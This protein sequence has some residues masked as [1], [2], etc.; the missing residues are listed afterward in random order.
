VPH[1]VDALELGRQAYADEAWVDAYE[2]FS[3]ADQELQLA[4]DDLELLARAA[5][6][7]GRDDD[8]VAALE[9][10]HHAHVSADDLEP[11]IRCA[12]WIGH[13]W[14]FRGDSSRAVGWF[15]RGQRLLERV[16]HDCVERGWLL[17]PVWLEQMGRGDYEVGYETALEAAR[18][19]ERF[20]DLDLTWLARDEQARALVK[21]GRAEEGLRLVGEVFVAT[22]A[23]ELSPIVTG[24]VYCNTVIFCHDGFAHRHART[25]TVGLTQ[26]CDRQPQ[27]VAHN[28]LCRVHRAEILELEGEWADALDEARQ[29]AEC[30]TQGA[31]NQIACGAAHYRQ[32]EIHRLRGDREDAAQSYHEASRHGFE[33]Q[34]GLALLRLAEGDSSAAAAAI[35]R[36]VGERTQPLERA[37]LLPAFVQ[38]MLAVGEHDRA[39]AG[40]DELE[41]IARTQV[42]EL[43]DAMSAH[44]RGELTLSEGDAAGALA[45]LRRAA[46]TWQAL[47]AP[48]ES[49]RVRVA[50]AVACRQLG[51]EEAAQ[52]ELAAA[53]A[54]FER[55]HARP[56]IDRVRALVDVVPAGQAYGLT[57]REL[58]VLRGLAAGGSNREIASA[59][60]I[61]EHTVAR[62]LQNIFVKLDVSSRT[63]ATAFAFAHDLV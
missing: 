45:P 59:L 14:L 3:T 6:M 62:H 22:S 1:G 39:S 41:G 49:A 27:M 33:P 24:I 58:Q 20:G 35:R 31:L 17:I 38:I 53:E 18:I 37:P 26:W 42:S 44:T 47:S 40:A 25:W 10:A 7:L 56:D 28:G 29:A 21:Q 16:E 5:Y 19:G 2:L 13:S 34:P 52:L 8:Y 32:G 36:T 15:G 50:T 60:F 4:P 54:V 48:Y 30:F 61:S 63:A 43:L 11:A 46:H 55:L 9:R 51:D 23:G 57:G 12:F